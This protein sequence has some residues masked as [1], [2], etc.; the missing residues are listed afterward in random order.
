LLMHSR[1]GFLVTVHDPCD[2][3]VAV[4]LAVDCG[5]QGAQ[6]AAVCEQYR[7]VRGL[8]GQQQ[9]DGGPEFSRRIAKVS[10]AS[11]W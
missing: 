7:V 3:E 11:V 8:K 10:S 4:V 5:V 2:A 1:A 9:G 6:H